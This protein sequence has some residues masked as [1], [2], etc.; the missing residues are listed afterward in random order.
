MNSKV[1]CLQT[2]AVHD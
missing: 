1:F 2:W